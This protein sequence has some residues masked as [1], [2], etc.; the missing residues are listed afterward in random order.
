MENSEINTTQNKT[1]AVNHEI[2]L[3][4]AE[5]AKWGNLLAIIGRY[6]KINETEY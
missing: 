1:F 6:Y 2:R 4:L 5:T 3:Y